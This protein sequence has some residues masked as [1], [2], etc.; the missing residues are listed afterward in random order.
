MDEN[1][2]KEL[3]VRQE[4]EEDK[5]KLIFKLIIYYKVCHLN[6]CPMR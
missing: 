5:S 3:G 6:T 1:K 2:G 4:Q